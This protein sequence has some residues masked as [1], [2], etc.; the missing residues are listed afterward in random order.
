M[1]S[2]KDFPAMG[3]SP[4]TGLLK[5]EEARFRHVFADI[6]CELILPEAES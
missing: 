2:V 4:G 3:A 1:G 5:G 6:A